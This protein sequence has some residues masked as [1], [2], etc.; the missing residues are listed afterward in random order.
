MT[1]KLLLFTLVLLGLVLGVTAKDKSKNTRHSSLV[2]SSFETKVDY[3]QSAYDKY[4]AGD[5]IGAARDFLA[6]CEE[7]YKGHTQ[8]EG[9]TIYNQNRRVYDTAAS[10]ALY[11]FFENEDWDGV[12]AVAPYAKRNPNLS[13]KSNYISILSEMYKTKKDTAMWVETLKEGAIA[14]PTRNYLNLLADYYTGHHRQQELYSFIDQILAKDEDNFGAWYQKGLA[15]YEQG[16]ND[17]ARLCFVKALAINEKNPQV[18]VM[19]ANTYITDVKQKIAS[20]EYKYYNQKLGYAPGNQQK[21]AAEKEDAMQYYF[22]A[23]LYLEKARAYAPDNVMMWGP[24]LKAVDEEMGL[25]QDA[26]LID[27]LLQ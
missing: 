25:V 2:T 4:E 24:S 8:A 13:S 19:L 12:A 1:K 6:F 15:L 11:F 9:D 27:K 17:D 14:C 21:T 10:N 23:K 22:N 3:N 16:K 26:A 18:N 7:P 5:K 20:G